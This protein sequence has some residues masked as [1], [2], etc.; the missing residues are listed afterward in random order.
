LH[1]ES[2][3]LSS[4]ILTQSV[5]LKRSAKDTSRTERK[6]E[7]NKPLYLIRYE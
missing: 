7:A 5:K 6:R 1:C 2:A 3:D 4:E